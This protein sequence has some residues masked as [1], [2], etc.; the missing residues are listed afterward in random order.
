[1]L[2]KS[3][4]EFENKQLGFMNDVLALRPKMADLAKSNPAVKLSMDSYDQ[5]IGE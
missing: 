4:T 2:K 5:K 1:M 3:T